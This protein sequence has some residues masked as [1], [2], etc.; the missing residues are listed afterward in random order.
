MS[1]S[2]SLKEVSGNRYQKYP[3]A[4]LNQSCRR[5]CIH[6]TTSSGAPWCVPTGIRGQKLK[7]G[8]IGILL[9]GMPSGG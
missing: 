7:G 1:L 9:T 8:H 4:D 3:A 6:S 5:I 2:D